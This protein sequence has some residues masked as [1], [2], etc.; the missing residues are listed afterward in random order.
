MRITGIRHRAYRARLDRPIGDANGPVG[1]D[2]ASGAF[3]FVDT[4]AGLTGIGPTSILDP[5]SLLRSLEQEL[6]GQDPRGVIGLW[7]RLCDRA[8]KR[9][10]RGATRILISA[11]DVALWDLK[12]KAN[13]E[14]LW[15]TLGGAEPRVRAYASGIDLN[16][17]DEDLRAFYRRMAGLG[18]GAGK[19]KVGLD[20]EADHRRL[21][22]V[23]DELSRVAERPVLMIDFERV[24]VTEA[25]D[26]CDHGARANL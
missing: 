20:P 22:I 7:A 16:L 21:G 8:F 10:V 5:G 6:L 3:I 9:G 4:D 17:S 1:S 26:P 2:E 14:P 18:I 12:A 25:G 11:L 23:R 13:D 24:L 19:L 15:R